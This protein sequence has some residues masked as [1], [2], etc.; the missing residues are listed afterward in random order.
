MQTPMGSSKDVAAVTVWRR[1]V[2][3]DDCSV[4][5]RVTVDL[6]GGFHL[7]EHVSFIGS[8]TSS[9]GNSPSSQHGEP[10]VQSSILQCVPYMIFLQLRP[11]METDYSNGE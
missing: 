5:E 3:V 9:D 6:A 4:E 11:Q 10:T 8:T 2:P 1:L 7:V